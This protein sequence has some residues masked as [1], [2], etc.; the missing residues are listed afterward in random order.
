[1]I[2]GVAVNLPFARAELPGDGFYDGRGTPSLK[3][4]PPFK[5]IQEGGSLTDASGA[6][7]FAYEFESPFFDGDP[8]PVVDASK[9]IAFCMGPEPPPRS[10]FARTPAA[11]GRTETCWQAASSA[12]S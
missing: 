12:I 8:V 7:A 3:P 1:M 11:A 9:A 5:E 6:G 4:L 10:T 2:E